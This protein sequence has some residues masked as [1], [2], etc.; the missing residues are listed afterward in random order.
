MTKAVKEIIDGLKFTMDMFLFNPSTGE[1]M[2]K[3]QL[4]DMNRIT[5]DACE[6]AIQLLEQQPCTDAI[7]RAE[8]IKV[9]SGFC[10]WSNIPK[11]LEKLPSVNTKPCEDAISRQAVLEKAYK[12]ARHDKNVYVVDVEDL[13]TLPSVTPAPKMGRW[14]IKKASIHPYGNDVAC[15]ECGHTM[16]SSFGYKYCPNCGAKMIEP[17]ESED[18]E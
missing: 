8:A 14:K 16:A 6:G 18:K 5:Y 13:Q 3:E 15:S 7:S 1:M 11:E 10:H 2:K 9:A 4:N 12:T 17:Q